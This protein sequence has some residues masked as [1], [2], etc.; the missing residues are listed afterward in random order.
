MLAGVIGT[1]S[2]A[3]SYGYKQRIRILIPN[4]TP[5]M[6]CL[7]LVL[8]LTACETHSVTTTIPVL[9]H[10]A[11]PIELEVE[12]CIDRT[13]T[14]GRDLGIEAKQAFEMRLADTEEFTLMNKGRYRLACEVTMFVKG[15][16]FKRWLMPGMG[17]TVGQVSAMVTD[18][19]NGE[20]VVLVEG[21]ATVAA[22]GLYSV[23]AEDYIIPTAVN[24]VVT[25][26]RDW[27]Q[28]KP[29]GTT[30]SA[31]DIPQGGSRNE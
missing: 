25:R 26:L 23:G 14:K 19:T 9:Q 30:D 10:V 15:S 5:R 28:G 29:T 18:T 24:D 3:L 22:G 31:T 17:A 11:G 7:W 13:E 12:Q 21:N 6:H 8:M 4:D 16:A 1:A 27:A 20:I 2:I